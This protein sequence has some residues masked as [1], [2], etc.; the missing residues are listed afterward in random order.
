MTE[1]MKDHLTRISIS[2]DVFFKIAL[3]YFR[4]KADI[5]VIIMGETG[6]GKTALV[7]LLSILIEYN[8]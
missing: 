1:N 4:L 8:F 2:E 6:I 5:P 7:E 3:I